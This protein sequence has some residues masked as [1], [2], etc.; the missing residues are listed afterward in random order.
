MAAT[1]VVEH[2]GQTYVRNRNEDIVP[3]TLSDDQQTSYQSKDD[4]KAGQ[5][6]ESDDG[7]VDFRLRGVSR[8]NHD[9]CCRPGQV[10]N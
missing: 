10:V 8:E 3:P 7:T 9:Y 2:L 4:R 5:Y 1:S 6:R